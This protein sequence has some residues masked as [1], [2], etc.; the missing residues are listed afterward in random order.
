M[1]AVLFDHFRS[2]FEQAEAD[3]IQTVWVGAEIRPIDSEKIPARKLN[4]A[5]LQPAIRVEE[6]ARKRRSRGMSCSVLSQALLRIPL[7]F[8]SHQQ[9]QPRGIAYIAEHVIG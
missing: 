4:R 5:M 1:P 2:A 7:F 6:G 9:L 8:L 3:K